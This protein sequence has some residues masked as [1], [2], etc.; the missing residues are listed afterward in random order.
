M[1]KEIVPVL[2]MKTCE[3]IRGAAPFILNLGTRKRGS[4]A[5]ALPGKTTPITF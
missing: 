3:G 2:A 4:T 5:A 1:A